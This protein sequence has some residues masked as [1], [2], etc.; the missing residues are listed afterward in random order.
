MTGRSDTTDIKRFSSGAL[1][2]SCN[3][4]GCLRA[5]LLHSCPLPS[6]L[7]GCAE[8]AA[9]ELR[10]EKKARHGWPGRWLHPIDC[11]KS[12]Q[13]GAGYAS[14][15][16]TAS[17]GGIGACELPPAHV[18]ALAPIGHCRDR[19]AG[20]RAG[21][22]GTGRGGD[23]ALLRGARGELL[24]EAAAAAGAPHR[25]PPPLPL[26]RRPLLPVVPRQALPPPPPRHCSIRLLL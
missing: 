1:P 22:V 15:G 26:P 13:G 16:G 8:G 11:I 18:P 25:P 17:G 10:S 6:N 20:A 3:K 4:K 7:L 2:A 5:I 19:A 12:R 14:D 23:G 21:G 24:P 9:A